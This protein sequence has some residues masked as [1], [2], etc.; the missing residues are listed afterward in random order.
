MM[1]VSGPGKFPFFLWKIPS[2][3]SSPFLP[4]LQRKFLLLPICP[5]LTCISQ[6]AQSLHSPF[7]QNWNPLSTVSSYSFRPLPTLDHRS[8]QL[9][10][11]F[12]Q[13]DLP[14]HC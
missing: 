8:L 5:L 4:T 14:L 9:G 7:L 2:S 11:K 13:L 6:S 10:S 12:L 3:V 1:A